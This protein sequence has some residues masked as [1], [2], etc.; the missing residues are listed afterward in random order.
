MAL[1][2]SDGDHPALGDLH[3]G[4]QYAGTESFFRVVPFSEW[5]R[6]RHSR[7]LYTLIPPKAAKHEFLWRMSTRRK[8][9]RFIRSS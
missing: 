4:H 3:S 2:S 8:P 1:L 5:A 6:S 9:T 7:S